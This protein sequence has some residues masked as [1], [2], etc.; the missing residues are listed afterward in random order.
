MLIIAA[1]EDYSFTGNQKH[2][3]TIY[4]P[5]LR[6]SPMLMAYAYM[7]S[8]LISEDLGQ[9]RPKASAGFSLSR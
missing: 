6:N 9:P 3:H 4:T 7:P 8:D 2:L 5:K 1:H